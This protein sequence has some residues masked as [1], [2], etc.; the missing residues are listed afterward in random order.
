MELELKCRKH[1]TRTRCTCLEGS[2]GYMQHVRRRRRI[3]RRQMIWRLRQ[4]HWQRRRIRWRRRI[5]LQCR[6]QRRRRIRWWR[7]WRRRC[8]IR[9][10]QGRGGAGA[11]ESRF[12]NSGC[13][14]RFHSDSRGGTGDGGFYCEGGDSRDSSTSTGLLSP[15]H[16]N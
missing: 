14:G 7:R 15:D 12:C 16:D 1:S 10:R 9:K 2:W 8:R 3:R 11:G 5:R 13:D 6:I 4:N